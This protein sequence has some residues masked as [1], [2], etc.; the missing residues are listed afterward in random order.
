MS[1]MIVDAK[2]LHDFM[3][4]E[5]IRLCSK[6]YCVL[7]WY[8]G[9]EDFPFKNTIRNI[10]EHDSD[11]YFKD[12]ESAV[13]FFNGVQIKKDVTGH[14]YTYIKIPNMNKATADELPEQEII[15]KPKQIPYIS[16]HLNEWF[17]TQMKKMDEFG[18]PGSAIDA[19]GNYVD[20][21]ILMLVCLENIK[22]QDIMECI[23]RG[24]LFGQETCNTKIFY[25]Y[26]DSISYYFLAKNNTELKKM[27]TD[28]LTKY[29]EA[30]DQIGDDHVLAINKKGNKHGNK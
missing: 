30:C 19:I 25:F 21:K 14:G 9:R 17:N 20:N 11:N 16:I 10:E 13:K 28:A 29:K 4:N 2:E 26:Y 15:S 23:N 27:V 7:E 3:R 22:K 12:L 24:I 8:P 18:G 5:P 6:T 1:D